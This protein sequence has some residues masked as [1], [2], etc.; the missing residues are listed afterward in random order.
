MNALILYNGL[1]LQ[2]DG[3]TAHKAKLATAWWHRNFTAFWLKEM[4]LPSP[5][6]LDIIDSELC[7]ILEQKACIVTQPSV[8]VLKKKSTDS[9]DQIERETVHATCAQVIQRL[10]RVIRGN[11]R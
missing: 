5:P 9:W 11:N 4:W 7:S 2:R 1:T 6:Y 8:E 10:R 3:A